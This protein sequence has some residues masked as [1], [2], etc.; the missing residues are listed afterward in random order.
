MKAWAS[1][2][3]MSTSQRKCHISA[4]LGVSAVGCKILILYCLSISFY[5][6]SFGIFLFGEPQFK[7]LLTFRS[8]LS[9]HTLRIITLFLSQVFFVIMLNNTISP[10]LQ[11]LMNL[12][13]RK[14]VFGDSDQVLHKLSCATTEHDSD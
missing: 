3:N 7:F 11:F 6:H 12:N 9:V 13:V 1:N 10:K 4:Y 14:L 2:L 8:F 5:L